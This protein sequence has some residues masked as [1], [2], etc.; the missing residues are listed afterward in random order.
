M[1]GAS[2]TV[3]LS[4]SDNGGPVLRVETLPYHDIDE[5]PRDVMSRLVGEASALND[6]LKATLPAATV[7]S[8]F[9]LM[10][11]DRVARHHV[12]P[13]AP[14]VESVRLEVGSDGWPDIVTTDAPTS[15]RR[16]VEDGA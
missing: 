2:V 16:G 9:A 8:L 4:P 15:G 1:S 11:A 10:A 14:R 5:G 7:D 3:I 12:G 13:R 6:A